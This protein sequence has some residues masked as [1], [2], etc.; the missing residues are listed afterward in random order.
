M[1]RN[2]ETVDHSTPKRRSPLDALLTGTAGLYGGGLSTLLAARLIVRDV[3]F[4]PAAF[5]AS[6]LHLMLLPSLALLPLALLQR[7]WKLAA[8]LLPPTARFLSSYGPAFLPRPAPAQTHEGSTF[9][10][11]TYNLHAELKAIDPMIAIIR[12]ANAD[13][14][15]LQELGLETAQRFETEFAALYPYRAFHPNDWPNAGQGVMSRFPVQED[16]YWQHAHIYDALGHQRVVVDVHG[17]RITLYNTHPVHP[18]MAETG[19]STGPRGQEIRDILARADKESGAVIIAG[20]FNMSDQ[21]DDYR[22]LAARY[23]DSY[24]EVGYGLGLSFP[25]WSQPQAR[26]SDLAHNL[27]FLPLLV[28]LDYVFHNAQL[29]PL[30]ARVWPGAGGSDHRPVLV[31]MALEPA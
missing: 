6:F 2:I 21:S 17:T 27:G 15:N 13:I 5:A 19:F 29:R 10:F 30:E 22:Y 23:G 26:T 14:V 16:V 20:D 8:L 4:A 25:D 11:L 28:R 18:G 9:S 31:R 24:R 3:A 12:A 1:V 7:R